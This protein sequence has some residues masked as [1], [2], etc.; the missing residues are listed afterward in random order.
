MAEILPFPRRLHFPLQ[1]KNFRQKT[2]SQKSHRTKETIGQKT[3][4]QRNYKTKSYKTKVLSEH[5]IKMSVT[6]KFIRS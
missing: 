6:K 3:C 2:M 5:E 4:K 1:R